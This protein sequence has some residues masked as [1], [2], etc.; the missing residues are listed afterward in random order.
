MGWQGGGR[1]MGN[2]TT[3]LAWSCVA[4]PP[5]T[6]FSHYRVTKYNIFA[7]FFNS[8]QNMQEVVFESTVWQSRLHCL[9]NKIRLSYAGLKIKTLFL[10][11]N[12]N[13]AHCECSDSVRDKT[14]ITTLPPTLHPSPPLSCWTYYTHYKWFKKA[15]SSDYQYDKLKIQIP[16]FD[17]GT[18]WN[19]SKQ[20]FKIE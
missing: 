6:S 20:Q 13:R 3:A 16:V 2:R 18:L 14:G 19:L 5:A 11:I 7:N 4:V 8:H 12:T 10:K 15:W 9:Q 17:I 1:L